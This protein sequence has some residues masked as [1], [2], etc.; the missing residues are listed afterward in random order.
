MHISRKDNIDLKDLRP[1]E[2]LVAVIRRHWIILIMLKWYLLWFT[3]FNVLMFGVFWFQLWISLIM[4]VFW[5]FFLIWLYIEWLNHELD[6]FIITDNRVIFVEQKSFLNR[7]KTE[8]NLWQI[9]EVKSTTSW[10]LPN[11]LWYGGLR[12][13]T[14]WSTDDL[15]MSFVPEPLEK[16]RTILN[17]ADKYRDRHSFRQQEDE[18]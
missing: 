10:L 7:S 3:L 1:W 12:I 5:M 16:V 17:I 2:K 11:L 18:S 6:I 14:A 8:C 9:Q 15:E 13:V 4:I